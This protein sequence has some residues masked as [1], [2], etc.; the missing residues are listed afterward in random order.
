MLSK[1]VLLSSTASGAIPHPPSVAIKA[2]DTCQ[3][4]DNIDNLQLFVSR[5]RS[6][7]HDICCSG[8]LQRLI[9]ISAIITITYNGRGVS[10]GEPVS[11]VVVDS[12]AA[13]RN[14]RRTSVGC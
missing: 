7:D 8:I 11:A 5:P 9:L 12:M 2:Q 10:V 14:Q 3:R 1:S 6:H 13:N 4:F